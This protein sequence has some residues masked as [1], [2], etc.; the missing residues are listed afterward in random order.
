[1]I[2]KRRFNVKS[3]PYWI[4]PDYLKPTL[5]DEVRENRAI[6]AF[7]QGNKCFYCEVTMTAVG[8]KEP[9]ACTAEH[10]VPRSQGG[11][12]DLHNIVAACLC[13]NTARSSTDWV[14]FLTK[15]KESNNVAKKILA[16]EP[17][18]GYTL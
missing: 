17:R 7:Q 2:I 10:L 1:M 11:T 13:C 18:I 6:R 3:A 5:M 9:T 16:I 12:N 14:V 15:H 8:N 4:N